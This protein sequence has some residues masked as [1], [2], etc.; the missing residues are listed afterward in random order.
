MPSA[1]IFSQ[2]ESFLTLTDKR[3]TVIAANMANIDTPGYKTQDIDFQ[4]AFS[5]A[6]TSADGQQ[7][8]VAVQHVRGLLERADGNNVD[9]DRESMLLS[10]TQLQYQMGTQLLKERFHQLLTAINGGA[11]GE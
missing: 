5:D 1:P 9:M 6:M 3:E 2:L 10:E 8:H 7:M 11:G 4:Q